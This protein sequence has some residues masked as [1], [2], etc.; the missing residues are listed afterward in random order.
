MIQAM[1]FEIKKIHPATI[2]TWDGRPYEHPDYTYVEVWLGGRMKRA[3][4][5][6]KAIDL[7]LKNAKEQLKDSY[8]R[9]W[10]PD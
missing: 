1:G 3:L 9:I 7:F 2:H 4:C 5:D 10:Y 6:N 8:G